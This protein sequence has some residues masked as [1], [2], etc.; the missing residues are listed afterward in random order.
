MKNHRYAPEEK[1]EAVSEWQRLRLAGLSG[2]Y[3]A[4]Q[5]GM[6]QASLYRWEKRIG[7][8]PDP[9]SPRD[10]ARRYGGLHVEMRQLQKRVVPLRVHEAGYV[11]KNIEA[12]CRGMPPELRA[13]W[14]RALQKAS[15]TQK[16]NGVTQ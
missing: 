16:R 9:P 1:A 10:A 4:C 13:I 11:E 5:M 6:S 7:R 14:E 8:L 12:T 3:A 2:H 15:M